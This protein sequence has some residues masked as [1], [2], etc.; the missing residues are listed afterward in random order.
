MIHQLKNY[1]L[2]NYAGLQNMK[3]KRLLEIATFIWFSQKLFFKLFE[4]SISALHCISYRNQPFDLQCKSNDRFLHEMQH[5]TEKG[6][7]L[8]QIMSVAIRLV[9]LDYRITP[10][11]HSS[12]TKN[13][14][15]NLPTCP[16]P[17]INESLPQSV[18][19]R[20]KEARVRR[21]PS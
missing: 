17:T 6:Q 16:Q 12:P 2:F 11:S 1:F 19:G 4:L 15:L 9:F 3:Q 14:P 7:N 5:W 8:F 21:K 13:E 10:L 18:E 20:M